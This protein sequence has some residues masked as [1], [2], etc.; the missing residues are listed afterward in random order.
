MANRLLLKLVGS[1]V[2][3]TIVI[4]SLFMAKTSMKERRLICDGGAAKEFLGTVFVSF[5][6]ALSEF[7]RVW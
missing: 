5:S 4:T 2:F 6:V 3:G 1:V 7:K